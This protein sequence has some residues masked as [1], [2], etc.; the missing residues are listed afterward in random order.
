MLKKLMGKKD[1]TTKIN[2]VVGQFEG[3]IAE[4]ESG[5]AM[6]NDRIGTNEAEVAVL[7]TENHLLSEVNTK[8]KNVRDG[9][10]AI[11]N[12]G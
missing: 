12:G 2:G 4:L 10:L 7:Q 11:I 1:G 8:A 9:L 3:M 6:N 5:A